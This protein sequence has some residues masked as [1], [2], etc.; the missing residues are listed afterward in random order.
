M[1]YRVRQVLAILI[2]LI[3]A[4][5]W[6]ITV[7]GIGPID[8]IKDRMSLGLDIKGGVYVVMEAD[9]NDIA[10]YSD[11]ELREVMEQTQTVIENRINAN[12][13]GEPTITIE[14]KNRLRVE[15][16][17]VEDPEE[18][19]ELIGATAKLQFMLADG[20]VVLEGE[21]VKNAE[22]G[23]DDQS[24][25]YAVNLKF[26]SKGADK[27][28][29]ATTKAYNGEVTSTMD[30]VGSGAIAIVL[31]GNIISAPNVN[32]PILGG[33]CSITGDFTQEEAQLLAAQINGGSLPITLT[34]V[35]SSVQSASIGYKALEMSVYAGLIGLLL[36]LL[37]MLYVY[38][39]LGL[40]ADIALLLYVVLILNIMA[41]MGNVLTLPG[42]AG[43]IV[44]IGMAVDAN[45]IIFSRIR[46]EIML[47]RTVRVATDTGSKRAM[48]TIVDSQITTLIAAVILYE[49]GTSAVKGF[50]Y[51]FMISIIIS[52]FTA[53]FIT[54]LYV[55]LFADTERFQKKT[56][57]GVR[58]NNTAVFALKRVLPVMSKRKI[59]YCI[60]A[61]I[62]IIGLAFGLIRG[63]NYGIDFTG[64]TMIQMDMGKQVKI[65][66][67]EKTLAPFNLDPEIIYAGS[68]NSQIVI[69][70]I[71]SLEKAE[72]AEVIDA[73]NEEFGTTDEDVLAEE[74]FGPSV[75]K[76]LR[77]NAILAIIIAAICM[78]IYIRIRFRQWKFG[79]ASMLGV[80]HDVLIVISFYAIF[81]I[82][83]N[84]PFI[85]G[86][87]TVVGYSINDT[88]VI[89]DRIRENIRYMKRG[90]LMETIDQSISQTF[91]RSLMT[92]ITTII[93]M[94][95]MV[96]MA[97]SA[98][99]EFVF[100]LMVGVI[101]GTY[102]SICVCSPIY[103]E[104]GRGGRTSEYQKQI[105]EAEKKATK[106][107]K[108]AYPGLPK[109]TTVK[110]SKAEDAKVLENEVLEPMVEE[111][112]VEAEAKAL[113]TE[114]V[115]A[116][117]T[118]EPAAEA[119]EAVEAEAVEA[120]EAP[121]PKA[122]VANNKANVNKKR[123][124]RYVK[125]NQNN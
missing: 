107:G 42:I 9:K 76:E 16:P 93:V 1:S 91:G 81:G 106:K 15:I 43:I 68:D 26:D 125:G 56:F 11:D 41:Y 73:I 47:G 69:R 4:F 51:T 109:K 119:V 59:F 64:G 58:E 100:P 66:E 88:I 101:A 65:S 74:F 83:V 80:L 6:L 112:I 99:R 48:T 90:T 123:S 72:R 62:L 79:G 78:M 46:E 118:A 85:A 35:T 55:K 34:E 77:N 70:T 30:G 25:G 67:V 120:A 94:V 44:G 5:G 49:I 117:E 27:F 114:A 103:Y 89:F 87:L 23:R 102:S 113:E 95:P 86:I 2:V 84:N 121:E 98:I 54:Q 92:S 63:L 20:T 32:E 37:L 105:R 75:G 50:A 21:N 110:K 111:P 104:L 12:G 97:G 57:F 39:G 40:A 31:D 13:L 14:G 33:R 24:T 36:I 52:I 45:V 96:I 53:V 122:P 82:T 3:V 115:E 7:K 29:E 38:R 17:E 116:V 19:I 60:S 18:A 8:S 61:G 28:G 108:K 124:K 71:E 10:K 22:A